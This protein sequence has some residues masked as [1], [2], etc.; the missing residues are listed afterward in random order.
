MVSAYLADVDFPP[1]A[2]VLEDR[3]GA[4]GRDERGGAPDRA[5]TRPVL[6]RSGPSWVERAKGIEPSPRAREA[7]SVCLSTSGDAGRG[8]RWLT[9]ADRWRPLWTAGWGTSGS[10]G[11]RSSPPGWCHCWAG[12]TNGPVSSWGSG[13]PAMPSMD[14]Q[15]ILVSTFGGRSGQATLSSQL[16]REACGLSVADRQRPLVP[17][18][19][20]TRVARLGSDVLIARAEHM[21][22]AHERCT[23]VYTGRTFRASCTGGRHGACSDHQRP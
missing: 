3:P 21:S 10:T 17:V 1:D 11:R 12:R 16:L 23:A 22:R 13:G 2:R 15:F 19:C 9:A 18:P 5:K 6:R 7:L 8:L 14:G 20:G 4:R